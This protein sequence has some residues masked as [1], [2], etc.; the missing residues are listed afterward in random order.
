MTELNTGTDIKIVTSILESMLP[1]T[2]YIIDEIVE[3]SGEDLTE[4][5]KQLAKGLLEATISK[6]I[7][8]DIGFWWRRDEQENS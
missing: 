4:V 8:Y 6:A 3:L 5:K 1:D 2:A 7:I